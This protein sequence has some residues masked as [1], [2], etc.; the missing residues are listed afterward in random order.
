[1]SDYYSIQQVGGTELAE[2][3]PDR[4]LIAD[5]KWHKA[6]LTAG[7]KASGWRRLFRKSERFLAV[8]SA[9]THG[10]S[11]LVCMQADARGG[12]VALGTPCRYF[13]VN[14]PRGRTSTLPPVSRQGDPLGI[15][16]A[17]SML[18]AW[19]IEFR[20]QHPGPAAFWPPIFGNRFR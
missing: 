3:Y 12:S 17:A 4:G 18:S 9:N 1:M 6:A 2:R 20:R 14:P 15:S 13:N 11:V 8:L 16:A 10:L 7:T 5:A 19:T